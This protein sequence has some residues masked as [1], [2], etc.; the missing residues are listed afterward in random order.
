MPALFSEV[1]A[2]VRAADPDQPLESL[3]TAEQMMA[4]WASPARFIG[5]LMSALAAL[6]LGLAAMGTY[7]VIAYGVS[8]RTRELGIRIALGASGRQIGRMV[9]GSALRLAVFALLLGVPGA[10]STTRMLEGVLFGTSPTDPV[11]FALAML[12]L[13]AVALGASWY[14]ARRAARL[15]PVRALRAE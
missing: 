7:G 10:F 3:Q 11:V 2:A 13:V 8:Q 15:D 5:L 4:A 6:A 1:R 14:P 12:G 9:T